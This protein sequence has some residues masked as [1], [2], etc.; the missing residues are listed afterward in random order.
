MKKIK[1]VVLASLLITNLH[2]QNYK[3]VKREGL[4]AFDL[5]YGIANDNNGNVYVGGKYELK[6][7]FSDTIL[8]CQGNHDIF[9]A[10]YTPSGK[11]TW[12]RTAG[13]Y[14]GDYARSIACDGTNYLYVGGEIEG[15]GAVIKFVG[16][17]IT[18]PTVGNNDA[19]LAKYDLNGNL[20]WAKS[21]GGPDSDETQ[22]ITYDAAGNVYVCGFFNNSITFETTTLTGSGGYDIFIAKYDA[23]GVFKWAKKIGRTGKDEA[24][25]IK[26]DASGYVYVCG[27][28][29]GR[30]AFGSGTQTISSKGR[31]D[32]FLA[33]YDPNG[34]LIWVKQ[35]GGTYD[36][37]A[38]SLTFDNA[39]KIYV[40]GE[41]GSNAAFGIT[42]LSSAGQSDI[43]VACFD[44]SGNALWARRAGGSAID[45]ARAIGSDGTNLYITGQFGSATASFGATT[46]QA[47][48]VSDVFMAKLDNAGN[49]KWATAVGGPV[50]SLEI[51]GFESGTAICAEAS[52][53]IY[54]TGAIEKGGIF[55]NIIINKYDHSDVF[56]AKM[57]D[58][59]TISFCRIPTGLVVD[60]LKSSSAT[61]KW[62]AVNN[63]LSYSVQYAKTGTN[64]WTTLNSSTNSI[65]I[66]GLTPSTSYEFQVKT[67]CSS[68]INNYSSSVSFITSGTGT[69]TGTELISAGSEWKY[70]DDG[71]NHGTTWKEAS[72]NDATWKTGN[73]ELG[74]GDGG[75]A[76]V[77]SYGPL[78]T[79]KYITT[80]FRKTFN[81]IDKSTI[82]GL[83]LS[84]IR[85][86]GAVVYINGVEV[87]RNN[88][89]SGTIYYNTL[90]PN[91]IDGI[92]ESTWLLANLSSSSLVNGSNVIAVEIHQNSLTSS[93]ISFNLKLKTLSGA[94]IRGP[95]DAVDKPKQKAIQENSC[96]MIV[97]PNP[98]TG[99]F[100]LEICINDL[101][102][103]IV[104]IEVANSLGQVVY[105][106]QAQK[107]N[108]CVNE[109]I[110]LESNLP[111]G[112]YIMKVAID[113]KIQ[114]SKMLLIK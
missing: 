49:F 4:W 79:N 76:T 62:T 81:V 19:F 60:S 66:S 73:A 56:I 72:F 105:K 6:A 30:V 22:G 40:S 34:T 32:A 97:S 55:G 23:N 28:F 78:S 52:G 41:F 107:I 15:K 77:V 42:T 58:S 87:Y 88:L 111:L 16:S 9:V 13:G 26:C 91:Y 95:I 2:S 93:D 68:G 113:D 33:K 71:L 89:P 99:K 59:V 39:G 92:Y 109:A 14:S 80:Y 45:R 70:I 44:A 75:E 21:A 3:W 12:I 96:D 65:G 98:N 86:D 25:S 5:G 46:L 47:G 74:Y 114:T 18:L 51:Y 17:P 37:E 31:T 11:L 35:M 100:N 101:Q 94:L 90:A 48:D 24:K 82:T 38:W 106:K 53:N 63:A 83:E 27:C 61:L 7:N 57:E 104:V 1:L 108:G 50:D 20:L 10:R 54:A 29:S 69:G 84:L 85:D 8:P 64:A 36:D 110:E 112:V 43:F 102:E 103:K 67:I